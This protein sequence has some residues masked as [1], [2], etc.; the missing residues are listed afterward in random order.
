M[1]IHNESC[2]FNFHTHLNLNNVRKSIFFFGKSVPIKQFFLSIKCSGRGRSTDKEGLVEICDWN[3]RVFVKFSKNMLAFWPR[4]EI[5]R[6]KGSIRK[7]QNYTCC[8]RIHVEV[9]YFKIPI[10]RSGSVGGM[11]VYRIFPRLTTIYFNNAS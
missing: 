6:L 2:S 9:S 8:G 3:R 4:V 1:T 10:F 5:N 11:H 7:P